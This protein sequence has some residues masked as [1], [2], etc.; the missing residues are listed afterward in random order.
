MAARAV[1]Y[2]GNGRA[3]K[4]VMARRE[5]ARGA[6]RMSYVRGGGKLRGEQTRKR[7][8]IC[9]A[10]G[11]HQGLYEGE[12]WMDFGVMVDWLI[13]FANNAFPFSFCCLLLMECHG[14]MIKEALKFGFYSVQMKVDFILSWEDWIRWK[15]YRWFVQ[16]RKIVLLLEDLFLVALHVWNINMYLRYVHA[17][18]DVYPVLLM[19]PGVPL[20]LTAF[21]M[22]K[23]LHAFNDELFLAH[24]YPSG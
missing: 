12:E 16:I 22:F 19:Y 3:I 17:K 5:R 4:W 15:L 10:W 23:E 7:Y 24:K 8:R 11:I 6:R 9:L 2:E 18:F 14:V 21:I 1:F 20:I 13:A